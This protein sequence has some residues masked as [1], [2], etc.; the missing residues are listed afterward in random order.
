M[1]AYQPSDDDRAVFVSE[2]DDRFR[3]ESGRERGE[4]R[5]VIRGA[6]GVPEKLYW[7]TYPFRREP[8][9]F[10]ELLRQ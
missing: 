10:G 6:D 3:V 8:F 7:A 1:P 2:G 5:R 9:T 4:V